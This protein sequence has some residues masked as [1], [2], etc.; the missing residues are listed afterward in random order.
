[1]TDYRLP[2]TTDRTLPP[3]VA[4]RHVLEAAAA[5]CAGH[6][7]AR[8]LYSYIAEALDELA[9]LEAVAEAEGAAS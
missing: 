6:P 2:P 5:L 7:V 4:L 9:F 3:T 8:A 1:V